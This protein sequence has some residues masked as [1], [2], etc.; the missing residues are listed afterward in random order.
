MNKIE[1]TRFMQQ[2][3]KRESLSTSR[4][5]ASHLLHEAYVTVGVGT[6]VMISIWVQTAV[7]AT[8]PSEHM[9]DDDDDN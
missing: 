3:A 1:P 4:V 7:N 8:I 9:V 2:S 6:A 5:L